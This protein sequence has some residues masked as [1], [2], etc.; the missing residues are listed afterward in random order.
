MFFTR[1]PG[2]L[3]RAF[4]VETSYVPV[5]AHED[6]FQTSMQWSRRFIGLKVFMTLASRGAERIAAGLERQVELGDEL[7]RMLVRRG[8][9]IVNDSPLPVV[10]FTHPGLQSR[11]VDHEVLAAHIRE[12]GEVW[13]SA[14]TI[15]GARAL[16]ACITSHRTTSEDLQQLMRS[17]HE[18]ANV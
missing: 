14:V 3:R 16:R 1:R 8:W 9:V 12:Q 2:A 4:N 5:E 11:G 18:S 15:G 7:R 17:L 13:V 10:C 6:L